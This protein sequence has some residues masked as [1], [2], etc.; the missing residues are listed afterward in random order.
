MQNVLGIDMNSQQ[1]QEI[2]L[3]V[4][5]DILQQETVQEDSQ[6]ASIDSL[7]DCM[8]HYLK[9]A[10]DAFVE[11][12]HKAEAQLKEWFAEDEDDETRLLSEEELDYVVGG[13]FKDF[14]KKIG[15]GIKK[16][17][18]AVGNFVKKNAAT[19]G[20][21]AGCIVAGALTGGG[22]AVAYGVGSGMV[23]LAGAGGFALGGA[24]TGGV[25]GGSCSAFIFA[26]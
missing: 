14:V 22:I 9:I 11:L 20:I 13:G 2:S 15:K 6:K 25:F 23:S 26:K 18:S 1:F 24:I 7:Y 19:I 4:M 17:A 21:V 8:C 10:K 16:G 12:Y 5:D 3:A